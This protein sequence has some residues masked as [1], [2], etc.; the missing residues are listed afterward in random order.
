MHSAL[1]ALG[2]SDGDKV[3]SPS[4][5]VIMNTTVTL[6]F[7]AIPFYVD[8]AANTYC[9]CPKDLRKKLKTK[10]KQFKLL[11]CMDNRQNMMK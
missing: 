7:G 8:V 10:L 1:L 2:V 11:V 6:Q 3:I 9:I 5:T 4:F